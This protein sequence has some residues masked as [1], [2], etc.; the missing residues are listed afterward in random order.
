MFGRE[1]DLFFFFISFFIGL[2]FVQ[3]AAPF[4]NVKDAVMFALV[5]N[6]FG[7]G[8]FHQG[9][10]WFAYLDCKNQAHWKKYATKRAIFYL[11]P[12]IIFALSI[13]GTLKYSALIT[14]V[15]VI[16]SVQHLVQ[17][18]VGILLLYHNYKDNEAIVARPIEAKSQQ[19]A[20]IAFTLI[21]WQHAFMD[22]GS[23]PVFGAVIFVCSFLAAALSLLYIWHTV[24]QIKNGKALNVPAFVFW[25][26]SVI[27]LC[28]LAFFGKLFTIGFLAPV[29]WHWWQYIGLNYKLVKNKYIGERVSNLPAVNAIVLFFFVCVTLVVLNIGLLVIQGHMSNS[30]V[31]IPLKDILLGVVFGFGFTHYFLDAFLW[32]FR[33]AYQRETILPYLKT[34]PQ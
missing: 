7:L 16:W 19:M 27:C 8:P 26:M 31:N 29:I 13:L 25:L 4:L 5:G 15:W 30:G 32:R 33:E 10:T 11:G 23:H 12:P 1:F 6:A 34:I 3:I 24:R 9:P 18:N 20:A 28:P 17:Q 22:E 21:F 14:A 2:L